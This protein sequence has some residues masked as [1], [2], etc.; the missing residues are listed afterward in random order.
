MP[1]R[2]P[3]ALVEGGPMGQQR[4]NLPAASYR[5]KILELLDNS[6]ACTLSIYR[7]PGA[8]KEMLVFSWL[9]DVTF[10]N[11]CQVLVVE[12]ETGCGKTTQ[13]PQ[14]VLEE[15][16][17]RGVPANIICTQVSS[18]NA[19]SSALFNIPP[20]R[21]TSPSPLPSPTLFLPLGLGRSFVSSGASQA[22][23]TFPLFP[24]LQPR[25][26]SAMGV[27]ER[28]AAERGE[29]IGGVVGY[30]IRLESKVSW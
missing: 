13:V 2:P 26:I 28:V 21:V 23:D 18:P 29:P 17:A 14:F 24:S 12:G 9:W 20:C 19:L 5:K 6:Q 7:P 10:C 11:C 15:A 22:P 1:S 8:P 4:Q 30:T 3:P 16:A 27:A 25:R